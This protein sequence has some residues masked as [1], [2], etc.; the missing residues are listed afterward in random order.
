MKDFWYDFDRYSDIE[1]DLNATYFFIPFRDR[2]GHINGRPA[3]RSRAVK[4]DLSDHT[5]LIARLK[6]MGNEIAL[7]GIDAWENEE[8]AVEETD[9]IRSSAGYDRPGIRMHWLYRDKNT[10]SVLEKAGIFYD[11]SIGFNDAVGFRA[12]TSQVFRMTGSGNILELPLLV[13]DTA[14][15]NKGRMGL[16]PGEAMEAISELVDKVGFF[17]GVFTVNWHTRSLGPERNWDTFYK[18][19]L[20]IL[21]EKGVWFACARDAVE[22]YAMRRKV[23][24][25]KISFQKGSVKLAINTS[26]NRELPPLQIRYYRPGEKTT[27][28][29]VD[30][31][32]SENKLVVPTEDPSCLEIVI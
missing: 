11:S 31:S 15:F 3:P 13:M 24:F 27:E 1:Q 9:E 21:R 2:P 18:D 12:G 19:L 28:I 14:L 6:S 16:E 8:A 5:S 7:H 25:R 17:G 29:P 10:P 4:Y 23:V 30:P 32:L 20:D 26:G 22:W